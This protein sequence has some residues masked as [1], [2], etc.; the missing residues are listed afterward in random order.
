MKEHPRITIYGQVPS[1]SNNYKA[2]E[3]GFYKSAAEKES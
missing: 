2:G 1:K 3:H